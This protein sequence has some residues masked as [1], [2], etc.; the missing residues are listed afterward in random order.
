MLSGARGEKDNGFAQD[1]D[2]SDL[3]RGPLVFGAILGARKPDCILQSPG[4]L[5]K[6]ITSKLSPESV[7]S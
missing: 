4:K 6:I 5:L 1:V 2:T 3:W 7:S